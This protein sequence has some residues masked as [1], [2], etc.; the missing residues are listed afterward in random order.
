MQSLAEALLVIKYQWP[1]IPCW[2]WD[3]CPCHA[4]PAYPARHLPCKR[5]TLR[6]P[7]GRRWTCTLR[8]WTT[9][10]RRWM[11]RRAAWRQP[12]SRCASAPGELVIALGAEV[13]PADTDE[14]PWLPR[15]ACLRCWV[16]SS[17]VLSCQA[18]PAACGARNGQRCTDRKNANK[19]CVYTIF[20]ALLS[21]W[22]CERAVDGGQ[23]GRWPEVKECKRGSRAVA[24]SC[25]RNRGVIAG[26][27][28]LCMLDA[29]K[30]GGCALG[31][32][33]KRKS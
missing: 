32:V 23:G 30:R 26:V 7:L 14:E 8:C 12:R 13:A 17:W 10:M 24:H 15:G 3:G 11:S 2:S 5:S 6:L 18:L 16:L 20:V 9:W 1:R 19:W 31:R 27:C 25:P 29:A 4:D 21:S 33:C 28:V 22:R